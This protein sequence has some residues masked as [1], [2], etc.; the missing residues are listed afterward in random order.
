MEQ[1]ARIIPTIHQVRTGPRG[2]APVVLIHPLGLDLTF[3]DRQIDYLCDEFDLVSFDL[4]G[5]GLSSGEAGDWELERVTEVLAQVVRDLGTA[6][7]HLVGISIGSM[8]AQ[9]FALRMP[10]ATRSLTLIGSAASF[11]VQ[12]RRYLSDIAE[13]ASSEGMRAIVDGSMPYWFSEATRAR[14]PDILDRAAKTLL[15]NA[16]QIHAAMWRMVAAF[17]LESELH[18]ITCPTLVLVGDQDVSTPPESSA[19]IAKLIPG[20]EFHILPGGAHML[21]IESPDL[22]NQCLAGFLR[23]TNAS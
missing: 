17:D 2:N 11:S 13:L 7:A 12:S 6:D 16:P 19:R 10:H 8:I 5:N 9:S 15:Q 22:V 14:R 21:P 23:K 4:P 18:R 1:N 20:A 3:W